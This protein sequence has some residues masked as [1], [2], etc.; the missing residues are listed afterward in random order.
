[1]FWP[2]HRLRFPVQFR[3]RH[4]AGGC[5]YLLKVC[6]EVTAG[7]VDCPPD[8]GNHGFGKYYVT[9]VLGVELYMD[10]K[11]FAEKQPL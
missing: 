10:G 11:L 1:M 6:N 8:P 7:V 4:H 9:E 2:L 5:C 3:N